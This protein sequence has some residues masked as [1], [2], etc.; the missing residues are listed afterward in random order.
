MQ[1]FSQYPV[2]TR[3]FR[4]P[5]ESK[6]SLCLKCVSWPPQGYQRPFHI[7]GQLNRNAFC[8]PGV[9]A[10]QCCGPPLHLIVLF[11]KQIFPK[12]NVLLVCILLPELRS[13]QLVFNVLVSLYHNK[14]LFRPYFLSPYLCHPVFYLPIVFK[15]F[16]NFN[17]GIVIWDDK[18]DVLAACVVCLLLALTVSIF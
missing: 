9:P 11:Q 13:D 16:A 1:V 10:D 6:L 5:Q 17:C 12:Y 15:Y 8:G 2:T 14:W 18:K 7:S 4:S 3:S